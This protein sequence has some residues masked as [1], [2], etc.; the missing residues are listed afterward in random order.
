MRYLQDLGLN[1]ES[2]E[3]LVPLE[4]VQAPALAEMSKEA[5]VEGWKTVGYVSSRI[6]INLNAFSPENSV[7]IR[8]QS[9]KHT[10]PAKLS[11]YPLT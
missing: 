7:P 9:K 4:I 1:L 2:A 11:N 3:I 6:R 8:S 10:L 5:F